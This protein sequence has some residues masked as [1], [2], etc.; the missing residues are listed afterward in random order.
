MGTENDIIDPSSAAGGSPIGTID[1]DIQLIY[2][3]DKPE[4]GY[5][6]PGDKIERI[7]VNESF[8]L[9]LPTM[10]ISLNDSGMFFHNV[11]FQIGNMFYIKITPNLGDPDL[12]PDAII[13]AKVV[14]QAM[15]HIYD[16]DRSDYLYKIHCMYGA[17]RYINDICVWPKNDTQAGK[18]ISIN[19]SYTSREVL[20]GILTQAGLK[21][22][23]YLNSPVDDSMPWLNSNLTYQ[24]FAKKIVEH[25]WIKNDDLPI[26]YIDRTGTACYTSLNS[27]CS[28][29][30]IGNYIDATRYQKIYNTTN[31]SVEKHDIYRVYN[32]VNLANYGFL[33]NNGGYNIKS[34]IFNPYNRKEMNLKSYPP[35]PFNV[36]N[37]SAVSKNDICFRQKDFKDKGINEKGAPRLANISNRSATQGETCRYT[38]VATHYK[39]THENYD[40]APVHHAS[41]RHAFFQQF[42]FMTIPVSDQPDYMANPKELLQLGDKIGIDFSTIANDTTVQTCNFIVTGLTH[43]FTFGTKYTIMATCVTDGIGGIG[44]LKKETKNTQ[45]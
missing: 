33:Q 16:A 21:F 36:T 11:N 42:A 29:V 34:C 41:I 27:L 5:I 13:E 9:P 39:Q 14:I 30:V 6:V 22:S 35:M 28:D 4:K 37:P 7:V 38:T 1:C 8:F 23:A 17:E 44:Q 15:E 40:F 26:L 12:S 19:K 10:T 20:E 45:R 2:G 43:E 25:A 3:S 32:S 31:N 18:T 24:E